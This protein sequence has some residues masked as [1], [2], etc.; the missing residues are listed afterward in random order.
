MQVGA[1]FPNGFH[2]G[3]GGS[4]AQQLTTISA[5]TDDFTVLDDDTAHGDIIIMS[6]FLSQGQG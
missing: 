6:G 5:P 1:G 3:M 2:L 4:I